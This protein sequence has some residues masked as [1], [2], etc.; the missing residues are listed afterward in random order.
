VESGLPDAILAIVVLAWSNQNGRCEG[1]CVQACL[2]LVL[3]RSWSCSRRPEV[4]EKV[5]CVR[6]CQPLSQWD[7]WVPVAIA[8]QNVHNAR[9]IIEGI[10]CSPCDSV[11]MAA[12]A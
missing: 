3:R 6:N 2:P 4:R 5:C 10:L 7:P 12:K 8:C 11:P 1:A 9:V